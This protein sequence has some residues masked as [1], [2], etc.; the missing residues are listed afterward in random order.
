MAAAVVTAQMDPASD[1]AFVRCERD[2]VVC[3]KPHPINSM[4]EMLLLTEK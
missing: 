1:P 2:E 3:L 4:V